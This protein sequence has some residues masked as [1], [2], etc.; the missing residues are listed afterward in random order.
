MSEQCCRSPLKPFLIC[1]LCAKVPSLMQGPFPIPTV[2]A[3]LLVLSAAASLKFLSIHADVLIF[4]LSSISA[5]L[6]ICT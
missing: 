6:W 5:E 3:A 1:Y 2:C 4:G